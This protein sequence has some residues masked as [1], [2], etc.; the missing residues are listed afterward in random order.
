MVTETF[1]LHV[2]HLSPAALCFTFTFQFLDVAHLDQI[3]LPSAA[4]WNN[5]LSIHLPQAF[6]WLH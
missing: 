5:H 1:L 6:Q 3:F 2:F 4:D